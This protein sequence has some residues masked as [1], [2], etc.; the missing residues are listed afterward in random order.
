MRKETRNLAQK[1]QSD[2]AKSCKHN[3]KIFWQYVK[4]KTSS[5]SGIGDIAVQ[6][7]NVKRII[8]NDKDKVDL[9]SEFF[10]SIYSAEYNDVFIRLPSAMPPGSMQKIVI[11]ESIVAKKLSEIKIDKSPGPDMLHP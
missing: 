2:I 10:S 6:D 8:S 7:G 4:S 3:P 5:F 9:F 1:I 11:T